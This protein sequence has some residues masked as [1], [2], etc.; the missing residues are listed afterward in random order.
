VSGNTIN[1][2]EIFSRVKQLSSTNFGRKIFGT[3]AQPVFVNLQDLEYKKL[4]KEDDDSEPVDP[5]GGLKSLKEGFVNNFSWGDMFSAFGALLLVAQ[6]KLFRNSGDKPGFVETI[7]KNIALVATFGGS[8]SAM[9]GRML[10]MHRKVALGDK[11]ADAKLKSAEKKGKKIFTEYSADQIAELIKQAEKLDKILVYKP[12]LR[13]MILERHEKDDIGGLFDG[14]PGTGKTEGVKCILG[15][16]AK[17][18]LTQGLQPVIAELNLAEFDDYLKE[19]HQQSADLIEGMQVVAGMGTGG[20]ASIVHGEGLLILELLIKK[21]QKLINKVNR[22]N[23][24]NPQ[25]QKLAVFIDEFDKIFDPRTLRGCDKLRLK[26]MLVQFN[27]L[28]VKANILLTSNTSLEEMI[29]EIKTQLKSSDG[30]DSQE[31]WKPMYDRIA[32]KNRSRIENPGAREQAEIVAS[33]LLKNFANNLDLQ[34]FGVTSL[35]SNNL[36]QARALLARPLEIIIQKLNLNLNGRHIGY[37]CDDLT[38]MLIG[39]ARELRS[40][41]GISDQEWEKLSGEEK[42]KR[43]NAKIDLRLVATTLANKSS[44]DRSALIAK[45][46]KKQAKNTDAN[47]RLIS[48][49]LKTAND[50]VAQRGEAKPEDIIQGLHRN[51][52]LAW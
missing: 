5:P 7:L 17:R 18:N 3:I 51:Y 32:S 40:Q 9:F 49:I 41:F 26:N 39:K 48:S 52:N 20:Q 24:T 16:W 23:Q 6:Q 36:E 15:K 46:D 27:E 34:S 37:A 4:E 50:L 12:G 2:G 42:I 31:I 44:N 8:S 21:I 30:D 11:Y 25:K 29:S 1:A 28:F 43:T 22:H 19:T 13:E 47:H 33:R 10:D 14:P 45:E 35:P 38:S